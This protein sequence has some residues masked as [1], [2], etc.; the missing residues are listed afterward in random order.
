MMRHTITTTRSARIHRA[1][2]EVLEPRRLMA[3]QPIQALDGVGNNAA[4][5]MFGAANQPFLRLAPAGY[6]DGTST[7]AGAGRVSARA[8]SNA[9]SAHPGGEIENNRELSAFVYAWGQFIDHDLDLTDSATP[10]ESLPIAVPTGDPSFD[11]ASTGGKT[12]PLTRSKYVTDPRGVRQQV[13]SVDAYIDA[14]MVYGSDAATATALRTLSGGKLKTSAGNLLPW[15]T[16]GVTMGTLGGPDSNWFAAGD[17]RANENVE[18]LAMH[19]LFVREHNRLADATA[20]GNPTWTDEQIYQ[21]VRRLVIGI[22]Q[23]IT[24]NEFLPALMGPTSLRPYAGYNPNVNATVSN[25]F[26]TAGFRFG[27]SMLQDDVEFMDNN[28]REVRAPVTL[29]EAF[30]NPQLLAETG[31]DPLLKYLATTNAE[32]IDTKVVD[33]LRNFLFGP[34]GAGGLDLVSLNIQRGRDHGLAD[35]N[36]TRAALGMPRVS[37]FAQITSDPELQSRLQATYGNVNNVDLWV[38][39][40]AE[41]HLP[42]SSLGPT[43]QRIVADQFSRSR[44]GDSYFY[45]SALSPADAQFVQSSRLSELIRRNSVIQNIQPNAFVFDVEIEGTVFTDNNA[46]G[47]RQAR[48]FGVGGVTLALVSESGEV[49]QSIRSAPDGRFRFSDV[50][51][52]DVKVRVQFDPRG[53]TTPGVRDFAITRGQEFTLVD[54]GVRPSVRALSDP[55]APP[56]PVGGA[57]VSLSA[58]DGEGC[59]PRELR[60]PGLGLRNPGLDLRDRT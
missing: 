6:G 43:F 20:A 23:A 12:I 37:S 32:E 59:R 15:N 58:A 40:L 28:A 30:F 2:L 39:G 22:V 5:P 60:T 29:A 55:I 45:L 47:R 24:Y 33:S 26:A 38:G 31:I 48:D 57:S 56:P 50:P 18:L 53:L 27:H 41:N 13:S 44:D 14:S 16:L 19:T 46:D 7:P 52:G 54:F 25:E 42:G 8:V 17:V 36:S 49:L 11:P 9:V 35:Y 21:R 51:I 4:R 10:S 34:P 1:V 3:G